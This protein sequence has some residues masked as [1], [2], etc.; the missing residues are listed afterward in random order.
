[1]FLVQSSRQRRARFGETVP[2][3]QTSMKQYGAAGWGGGA[4][5]GGGGR[6]G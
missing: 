2:G 4:G 5:G 3:Q 6:G 1:M